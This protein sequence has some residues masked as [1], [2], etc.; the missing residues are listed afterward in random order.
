MKDIIEI[1]DDYRDL[2]I[3]NRKIT[4]GKEFDLVRSYIDFRSNIFEA[5]SVKKLAIFIESK[6]NNTYPDIVFV[7]YNPENYSL[8]NRQRSELKNQDL[9]ILYH[10]YI[11]SGLHA[12][13]I[14][15]QLGVSWK[16][17]L[18]SIER[19]YDSNLIIRKENRWLISDAEKIS[20][21]K[22]EAVEAKL[23]KWDQ[24]LQQTIIN[25]N[26][27]SE[28]YALSVEESK[29]KTEILKKF[30]RFGI[31]VCLKNGETFRTLKKAKISTMP[32]SFNSI[33]I[34]EWIGK[35]ISLEMEG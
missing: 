9:K 12:T 13:D 23:N 22:I 14:V 25:K 21:L 19:L 7:E 18:L 6:V 8:W 4:K 5:S 24:V 35:I 10:I 32:V 16:D 17:A 28:S 33:C 27:A 31:G 34:N 1:Y 15:N 11:Q 2:G 20:V 26:F 30:N 3:L 29:P